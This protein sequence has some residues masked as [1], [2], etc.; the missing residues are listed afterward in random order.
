MSRLRAL[1]AAGFAVLAMSLVAVVN[2]STAET[3]AATIQGFTLQHGNATGAFGYEGAGVHINGASPTVAGN[4]IVANTSCANGVGISV[5]FAS[6][7][8]RDNAIDGNTKQPGCS[9][10]NGGGIYVRGA[11]SAQIIHN[12]I[13]NNTTDFGGGIS[14]FAAGTPTLLNNTI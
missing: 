11:S 10:Q 1:S 2:F 4:N 6:P 7:V 9:G 12:S 5:A 14:L 8:I 13:F 3:A